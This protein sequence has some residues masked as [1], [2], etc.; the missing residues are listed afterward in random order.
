[1]S[2]EETFRDQDEG[3]PVAMPVWFYLFL[4]LAALIVVS[5]VCGVID[6]KA[7]AEQV[8]TDTVRLE[9]LRV[10]VQ[11]SSVVENATIWEKTQ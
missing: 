9:H 3:Y 5:L 7:E 8:I 2:T 11:Y 6:G 4:G 10:P 1:M